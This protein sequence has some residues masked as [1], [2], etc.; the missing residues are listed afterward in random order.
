L[1]KRNFHM[2]P[3]RPDRKIHPNEDERRCHEH[4][5]LNVRAFPPLGN[6][7]GTN[8]RRLDMLEKRARDAVSEVAERDARRIVAIWTPHLF[9]SAFFRALSRFFPSVL[10][11]DPKGSCGSVFGVSAADCAPRRAGQRRPEIKLLVAFSLVAAPA[12]LATVFVA[13]NYPLVFEDL[14]A[15]L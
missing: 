13:G 6:P 15:V 10:F 12:T 1:P 5:T 8:H 4:P 11:G 7:I 9:A 3:G 14:Y 2:L